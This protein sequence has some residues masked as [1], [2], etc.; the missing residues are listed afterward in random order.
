MSL[1]A[2]GVKLNA[3]ILKLTMEGILY[4]VFFFLE[5]SN[6]IAIFSHSFCSTEVKNAKVSI[7]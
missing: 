6:L 4:Y 3:S 5:N 7:K 2:P 1:I